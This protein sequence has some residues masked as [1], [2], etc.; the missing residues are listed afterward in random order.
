MEDHATTEIIPMSSQGAV[1]TVIDPAQ[2]VTDGAP[3]APTVTEPVAP[4]T[5]PE[6]PVSKRQYFVQAELARRAQ[7]QAKAQ[8]DAFATERAAF[9]S[10]RKA[11]EEQQQALQRDPLG[12]LSKYGHNLDSL[13]R[14]ALGTP[15]E[16]AEAARATAELPPETAK[17]FREM[18]E[19]MRQLREYAAAQKQEQSAAANRAYRENNLR[20]RFGEAQA[21]PEEFELFLANPEVGV[22]VY[23]EEWARFANTDL[24]RTRLPTDA[25]CNQILRRAEKRMTEQYEKQVELLAKTKRF[26]SRFAPKPQVAPREAAIR[27]ITNDAARP[28]PGAQ[29]STVP[30]RTARQI[31][32]DKD[33]EIMA[34]YFSSS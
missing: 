20:A 4:E 24:R 26:S 11:W 6:P 29:Q 28:L 1:E 13:A 9:E 15:A 10:Q 17:Q 12:A 16:K 5:K 8:A 2:G 27:T 25:E 7:A 31:L 30:N 21:E 34:K 14:L 32:A 23:E 3:Q 19:E 18:T 33:K 22:A